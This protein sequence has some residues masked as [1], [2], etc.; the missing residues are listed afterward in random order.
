[1]LFFFPTL[2]R[3][4]HLSL[5]N[6]IKIDYNE[7]PYHKYRMERENDRSLEIARL[8]GKGI[9]SFQFNKSSFPLIEK[10]IN[11]IWSSKKVFSNNSHELSA[12]SLFILWDLLNAHRLT[13]DNNYLIKGFEIIQSWME[14]NK[15]F[16]PFISK[17]AWWDY[18]TA[19]RTTAI[20]YFWDYSNQ[21]LTSDES[22]QKDINKYL[23]DALYYL[24][25][26]QN[27]IY[28][29]N[30]G[31]FEDIALML[32]SKHI[33]DP[34]LRNRYSSMAITRFGNQVISAFSREGFHLENSPG[35]HFL[36]VDLCDYFLSL[37]IDFSR[38]HKNVLSKIENAHKVQNNLI[39]SEQRLPEVG[40]TNWFVDV[41][42]INSIN[43]PH[44]IDSLAGYEI[45]KT[46]EKY[47]L[48]RTQ[49]I[50][51]THLHNDAL[52][53]IYSTSDGSII[54]EVGFLDHTNS[55]DRFYSKSYQ[56]HNVLIPSNKLDDFSYGMTGFFRCWGQD[57]NLFYS[58]LEG[59]SRDEKIIR[60]F[61]ADF[62]KNYLIIKDI[63][64][65]SDVFEWTR[66][67]HL[68]DNIVNIIIYNDYLLELETANNETY[69][70]TSYQNPL[71]IISAQEKPKIGWRAIPLENL[72]PS[73]TIFQKSS[74]NRSF[75]LALSKDYPIEFHYCSNDQITFSQDDNQ[76]T[77]ETGKD[78]LDF[79]GKKIM[80]NYYQ[81]S[82]Y[83]KRN[84]PAKT[85]LQFPRKITLFLYN[86]FAL[87]L[88]FFI[89]LLIYLFSKNKMNVNILTILFIS[90]SLFSIL[91]VVYIRHIN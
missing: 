48:I 60:N 22:F 40:D 71:T 35:Y 34:D 12:H 37:I 1:M 63:L 3:E 39:I 49:S 65:K 55:Y 2:Y 54:S 80:N 79:N 19:E 6:F 75:V 52:S 69:F 61:Y 42:E 57:D 44:L 53:F 62:Y 10:E 70:L 7:L 14:N 4:Y 41:N 88:S 26:P 31:I 30:H 56:A 46:H 78:F 67:F 51:K 21:F 43:K 68:S 29:H 24:I 18:S 86:S 72:H 58:S 66:L 28:E 17:Y 25:N 47:L 36:C 15:R 82:E 45:V 85:G 74:K 89:I 38:I 27:Y 16:D 87:L 73:N 77:I 84:K 64:N 20:L 90:T 91:Y 33:S 50:L 13:F 8:S 59:K 76:I 81:K 9:Y 83:F 11:D 32:L 23:N 5:I